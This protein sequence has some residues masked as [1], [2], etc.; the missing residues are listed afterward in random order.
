M[1]FS[2]YPGMDDGNNPNRL[3][4]IS[5]S[6]LPADHGILP[7][8][9]GISIPPPSHNKSKMLP[10]PIPSTKG[11]EEEK[12]ES[13]VGGILIDLTEDR[14]EDGT[15]T[16]SVN[17]A[18]AIPPAPIEKDAGMIPPP[19]TEK[20]T[21]MIPP[22]P[23]VNEVGTPPA[24]PTGKE[25]STTPQK[26]TDPKQKGTPKPDRPA[27]PGGDSSSSD[28]QDSVDDEYSSHFLHL[29]SIDPDCRRMLDDETKMLA[30]HERNMGYNAVPIIQ[31]ALNE[32]PKLFTEARAL[33]PAAVYTMHEVIV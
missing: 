17:D 18:G 15:S 10:L 30:H 29:L 20:A 23:T 31:Q 4:T 6:V 11:K 26:P 2:Y 19:S 28:D 5:P 27:T 22:A 21:S 13:N 24:A 7:A 9:H 12:D 14:S 16:P 8:D 33:I 32:D 25:T 1:P 3:H